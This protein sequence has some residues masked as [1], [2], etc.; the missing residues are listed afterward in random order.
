MLRIPPHCLL[1][2]PTSQSN[3]NLPFPPQEVHSI[4]SVAERLDLAVATEGVQGGGVGLVHAQ[5][6]AR[7]EDVHLAARGEKPTNKKKGALNKVWA[8]YNN[9]LTW[10]KAIWGWFPLLSLTNHD[11]QWARSELVVSSL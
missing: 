4:F 11:F 6:L 5:A 3:S 9:S 8:N 10:I 1:T 7:E 2:K